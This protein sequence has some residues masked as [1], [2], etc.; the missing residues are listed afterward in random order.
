MGVDNRRGFSPEIPKDAAEVSRIQ[1]TRG[2]ASAKSRR[3]FDRQSGGSAR[4][5][6][7]STEPARPFDQAFRHPSAW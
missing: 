2:N 7:S 4:S 5:W 6:T 1:L 3:Y